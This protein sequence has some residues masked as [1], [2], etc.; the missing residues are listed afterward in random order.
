[1][2]IMNFGHRSISALDK[3]MRFMTCLVLFVSMMMPASSVF[4]CLSTSG[5]ECGCCS[6]STLSD[7]GCCSAKPAPVEP[8]EP[9]GCCS[10]EMETHEEPC[11]EKLSTCCVHINV[12]SEPATTASPSALYPGITDSTSSLL[13]AQGLGFEK[14][15]TVRSS[16]FP[17]ESPPL[18]IQLC[19]LRI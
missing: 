14:Q 9:E 15:I 4:A 5:V 17:S 7:A 12:P 6:E 10:S 3:G 2:F 8:T 19:S 11:G 1:M 13:P 18:H 16:A